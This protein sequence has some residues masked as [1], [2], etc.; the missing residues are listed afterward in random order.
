[1]LRADYYCIQSQLFSHATMNVFQQSRLLW[2]H[3]KRISSD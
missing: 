2:K 3:T 1:M